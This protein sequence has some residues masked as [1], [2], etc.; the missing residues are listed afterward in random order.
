MHKDNI[1]TGQRVVVTLN[2]PR[3]LHGT[4]KFI[5]RINSIPGDFW[6]GIELNEPHPDGHDG[7]LEGRFYFNCRAYHGV[8]AAPNQIE[9]ESTYF[10][11]L[12][13]KS[14]YKSSYVREPSPELKAEVDDFKITPAD[15]IPN[16]DR[17]DYHLRHPIGTRPAIID[18]FDTV[19]SSD[20]PVAGFGL[21]TR[22]LLTS[23][24][25]SIPM[26]HM[27]TADVNKFDWRRVASG[28]SRA[29]VPRYWIDD[30]EAVKKALKMPLW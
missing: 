25:P 2:S 4:V 8:F 12:R 17:P 23:K 29:H 3:K 27:K 11:R 26:P 7:N 21:D 10:R 18:D 20:K 24:G 14:A 28:K 5:G 16:Q 1:R 19:F 15:G 13:I 22:R 9:L 30:K 6:V